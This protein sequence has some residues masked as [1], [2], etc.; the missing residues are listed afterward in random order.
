MFILIVTLIIPLEPHQ[1]AF[2]GVLLPPAALS[3]WNFIDL[4][5]SC[6]LE[7]IKWWLPNWVKKVQLFNSSSS[8]SRLSF[9]LLHVVQIQDILL[10]RFSSDFFQRGITLERETIRTRKNTGQLFFHEE[11]IYAISKPSIHCS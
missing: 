5:I 7:Q 10:A 6:L 4:V 1:T 2:L 8:I 9:K 11:S 3:S